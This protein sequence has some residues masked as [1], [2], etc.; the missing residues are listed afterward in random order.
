MQHPVHKNYILYNCENGLFLQNRNAL[1]ENLGVTQINFDTSFIELVVKKRLRYNISKFVAECKLQ[2]LMRKNEVLLYNDGDEFNVSL[3][4]IRVVELPNSSPNK[5][6]Y[7]ILV[8]DEVDNETQ[9]KSVASA[10]RATQVRGVLV[11]ACIEKQVEKVKSKNGKTYV[12]EKV[13]FKVD[14]YSNLVNTEKNEK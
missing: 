3:S 5:S 7:Y 10:S 9:Y 6:A 8:R 2:R 14:N 11:K 1:T 4:N 13:E 12:F